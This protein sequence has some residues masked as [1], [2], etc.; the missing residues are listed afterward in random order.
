M[1]GNIVKPVINTAF[2]VVNKRHKNLPTLN[3]RLKSG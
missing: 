2:L 1:F 3:V